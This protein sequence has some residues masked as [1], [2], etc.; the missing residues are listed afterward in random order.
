MRFSILLS[1]LLFSSL[2]FGQAIYSGP[3]L[4][5]STPREVAVWVQ[6]DQPAEIHLQYW[7]KGK[8]E[9]KFTSKVVLVND[10]SYLTG[11]LK[12]TGLEPGSN[13]IY[14]ILAKDKNLTKT[15]SLNFS[16]QTLWQHRTPAPDF[17]FLAGSCVYINDTA[18]DRPGEP[19]GRAYDIF[20]KMT[21]EPAEFMLW[22]GDNTYLR[23]VD[24]DIPDGINY[25][26][27]HSR[28][29]P[30]MQPFLA[31]MNH[32]AIWDDHDYGPND[33]D[34][35]YFGKAWAKEI[36]N[37][38]WANLHTEIPGLETNTNTF[39]WNDCQFFLLDNRWV[40]SAPDPD[41]Q[42]LGDEQI[43]WL[44]EALRF[45][46]ASFKFIAI[47][48]QF[49]SNAK[50]YEN[51]ANYETERLKLIGLLDK[52]EIKN[53]IFLDGDRHHAEFSKMITPMGNT[54]WDITTSPL[55]SGAYDHSDEPNSFR[56]PGSMYGDNNYCLIEVSGEYGKRQCQVILKNKAGEKV[57][58]LLI[59]QE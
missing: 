4:G 22:L 7:T 46:Q 3:M 52:H 36:F 51:H 23:E 56:I 34:G 2:L 47:G 28:H 10:E 13:Y 59:H 1:I 43:E 42:I 25:R 14:E 12:A 35:S 16:T 40:R 33:S 38:Y 31:A 24:W 17:S 57:R 8:P 29:T 49:V 11:T 32:Y 21:L 19:Y 6:L 15:K 55:T 18:Y 58:E 9:Q 53:V 41:G 54:L 27:R 48:G 39:T 26:H 5:Y 30:E 50:I 44:I 45:S 20:N 37:K